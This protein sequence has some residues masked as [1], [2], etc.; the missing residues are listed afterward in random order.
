MLG[1][2]LISHA[3]LCT[4]ML[5]AAEMICGEADPQIAAVS[6]LPD[7]RPEEFDLELERAILRVDS[8]DGVA[9]LADLAGGTPFNR[10][11]RFSGEKVRLMG[12]VNLTFFLELLSCRE[13]AR[14]D[15]PELLR[16]GQVGLREFVPAP[17]PD[18][19]I[20]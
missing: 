10:A 6:L 16:M 11:A 3:D 8:G 4:A 20:L 5:R 12:G 1:I 2:V 13:D 9:L 14:I 19:D 7:S 15:Y 18:D 17:Q